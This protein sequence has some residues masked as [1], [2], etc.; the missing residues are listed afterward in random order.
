MLLREA[1]GGNA[2]C[3]GESALTSDEK[4]NYDFTPSIISLWA[5]AFGFEYIYD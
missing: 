3:S 1:P 4:S 5:T 2:S